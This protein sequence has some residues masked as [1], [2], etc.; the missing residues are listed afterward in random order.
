M[1]VRIGSWVSSLKILKLKLKED[2]STFFCFF[3]KANKTKT[4]KK[5]MKGKS[6][7]FF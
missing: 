3:L 7:F 5:E 2:D 1:G 6:F 4:N